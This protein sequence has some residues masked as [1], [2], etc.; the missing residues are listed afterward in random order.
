MPMADQTREQGPAERGI[1]Q[2]RQAAAVQICR[3]VY[4]GTLTMRE[5]GEL[6]LPRYPLETEERYRERLRNAVLFNA[7]KRTV[8]GLVGMVFRKDPQLGDDVPV[9]IRGDMERGIIGH[10]ENI[11]NAGRHGTV[12][13]HDV[14]ENAKV[15]GHAHILVDYPEV[16][17]DRIPTA[18][19]ERNAELRP[20]W[21]D[22][23]KRAVLRAQ[24]E[25]IDGR[26]VLI[27]FA[28]LETTTE[29]DGEFGEREVA[30][31][32]QFTRTVDD[33]GRPA[34]LLDTWRREVEH[35]GTEWRTRWIHEGQ[36]TLMRSR[37]E[38]YPVIPVT[39]VYTNRT[40]FHESEP[41]LLDLALENIDHWQIRSDRKTS[42]HIAGVPVPI[43]I[44]VQRDESGSIPVS[45]EHGVILPLGGDAKY[46]EPT[47]AALSH[48]RE[49]LQDIEQRMAALGLSML[50]RQTRAAETAE[51]K[52]LDKAEAD[53]ALV[54]AARGL[55]DALEEAL[56]FHALWLGLG[57]GGS[58]AVNR[59]YDTLMLDPQVVA[60]LREMVRDGLLTIDTLWDALEKGEWLPDTFDRDRERAMLATG[61][62]PL[63]LPDP[64]ED[65]GD[66]DDDDAAGE[67]GEEA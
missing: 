53:S 56:Y 12:F 57:D 23:P 17:P 38:P 3:D 43:F 10:W 33:A 6:Y 19:D 55:E 30:R 20:Y 64:D 29:P 2:Q 46:M 63:P 26:T 24:G 62:L 18:A 52:R 25:T 65:V 11:D 5:R 15:D 21:V 9:Q 22:I 60:Q 61:A 39:T 34:V 50:V 35:V 36:R 7:F 42:L 66:P 47:G 4:A 51:A 45:S 40:G 41:P 49:E 54:A 58:L 48:S 32:R 1:A 28:Y 8:K 13:A 27:R 44:G 37:T 31:V 59:D 67:G 16:D 14:F